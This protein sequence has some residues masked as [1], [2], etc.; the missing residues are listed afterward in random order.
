MLIAIAIAEEIQGLQKIALKFWASEFSL[1]FAKSWT[2]I[3]LRLWRGLHAQNNKISNLSDNTIEIHPSSNQY[4]SNF[5]QKSRKT[6][7]LK[8][9]MQSFVILGS[10]LQWRWQWASIG[11]FVF[12]LNKSWPPPYARRFVKCCC[13][14]Y[15]VCFWAFNRLRKKNHANSHTFRW[16]WDF[17]MS[18]NMWRS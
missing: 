18:Q 7:K 13:K 4:N 15:K 6:P 9:L 3:L 12:L 8:T 5:L 17:F 1:A 14:F 10:L 2:H 11:H 16:F